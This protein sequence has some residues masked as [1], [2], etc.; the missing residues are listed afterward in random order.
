MKKLSVE[1]KNINFEYMIFSND[2]KKLISSGVVGIDVESSIPNKKS[3]FYI[4]LDPSKDTIDLVLEVSNFH[5][6]NGGI[7]Y[8]I[9]IG[10]RDIIQETKDSKL[11][12]DLFITGILSIMG[13]YHLSLFMLLKKDKS[14]LYFGI[15]SIVL[16]IRTLLTGEHYLYTI[17]PSLSYTTGLKIEYLTLYLGTPIFLEFVFF[18]C[19]SFT[20]Q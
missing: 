11:A 4:D 5:N 19:L 20:P 18:L 12:I 9:S 13:A 14:S 3:M 17:L 16:S 1:N 8:S 10:G 7:W 6:K 2:G 15:I